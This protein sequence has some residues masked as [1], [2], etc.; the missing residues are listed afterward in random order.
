MLDSRI[1]PFID[2]PLDAMA[3]SVVSWGITA[4]QL[5]W[6]GFVLGMLAVPS[7]WLEWYGVALMLL[8]INRLCDGLDGA[9]ARRTAKTDLGGYL[10]IVLDFIFYS[11]FVFGFCLAQ[12]QDAVYGAFL[13]F[14]FI[15]TG[16][17]FLAY[18]IIAEKR[19]VTT[20]AQGD[21][22]IYYLSG[23]AEGFETIVALAL[24]CL[25]PSQF[26]LLAVGFGVVCWLS[27]VGRIGSA[28][29]TFR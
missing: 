16:T 2:P 29:Q 15:G 20:K 4:N 28:I 11:A 26:W 13:I 6:G 7:I 17:S 14:S 18:A 1:R 27:T 9:V 8:L 24:M 21:K 12:P 3:G 22:S 25:L 19:G 23:I 10:D 5:T